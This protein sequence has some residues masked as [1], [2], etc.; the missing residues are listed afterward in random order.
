MTV[1]ST[2]RKVLKP[3]VIG[4]GSLIVLKIASMYGAYDLYSTL[5]RIKDLP[6]ST[7]EEFEKAYRKFGNAFFD[8]IVPDWYIE[9]RK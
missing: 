1:L 9:G 6:P 7:N 4:G 5:H 3:L 2:A 8:N